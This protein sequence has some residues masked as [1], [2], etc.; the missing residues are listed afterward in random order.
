MASVVGS[1]PSP[2]PFAH[3]A[4]SH[5]YA[6][7][8][9]AFHSYG[10]SPQDSSPYG[11]NIAP[12][13]NDPS[14]NFLFSDFL[15]GDDL[16]NFDGPAGSGHPSEPGFSMPMDAPA[17]P[18]TV[19]QPSHSRPESGIYHLDGQATGSESERHMYSGDFRPET[20][21]QSVHPF[22]TASAHRAFPPVTIP[23]SSHNTNWAYN[24]LQDFDFNNTLL[25]DL[26]SAS[27]Y[28]TLSTDQDP[29]SPVQQRNHGSIGSEANLFG[30]AT[31]LA[32]N[33][34]F[35][36]QSSPSFQPIHTPSS[37]HS[38]ASTHAN[39]FPGT[40]SPLAVPGP[41]HCFFYRQDAQ[42]GAKYL[43]GQTQPGIDLQIPKSGADLA[44]TLPRPLVE[45]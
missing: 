38:P 28:T 23:Q 9:D 20:H 18:S 35:S 11:Q 10:D 14:M 37:T 45:H 31:E 29:W 15:S 27:S 39:L 25:Q 19:V 2:T 44:A 26:P 22:T 4:T 7:D 43:H 17:L 34:A 16:V 1:S 5:G 12:A 3:G 21:Q 32:D 30:P 24:G 13:A 42:A 33:Y 6:G 40:H 36:W 8:F 41:E